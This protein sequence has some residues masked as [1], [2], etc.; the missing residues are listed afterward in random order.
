MNHIKSTTLSNC[1]KEPIHIPGAIQPFAYV[2]ILDSLFQVVAV[3]ENIGLLLNLK[4]EQCIGRNISEIPLLNSISG[5]EIQANNIITDVYFNNSSYT[6]HV[7]DLAPKN[8]YIFLEIESS[9]RNLEML[10]EQQIALQKLAADFTGK[11]ESQDFFDA[12]VENIRNYTG[13]DRCM[14]Y[15]FDKDWNG[16][17]IAESKEAKLEAFKG[18]HYPHTDIPTQARELYTKKLTRMIHDVNYSPV[19]LIQAS[20]DSS[21]IDLSKIDSRAIS[22]MHIQYLSNMGVKATLVLSLLVEGKLW[23]LIACHHYGSE[24]LLNYAER[25]ACGTF[26]LMV[27]L[28]VERMQRETLSQRQAGVLKKLS[29]MALMGILEKPF[30]GRE[31]ANTLLN[32]TQCDGIAFVEGKTIHT[33]KRVVSTEF[34]PELCKESDIK[35][36][37]PRCFSSLAWLDSDESK[38]AGCAGAIVLALPNANDNNCQRNYIVLFRKEITQ[39]VNWAGNPNEK[40]QQAVLNDVTMLSPRN[41]FALWQE[42]MSGSCRDWTEADLQIINSLHALLK[43]AYF[44][45]SQK[46]KNIEIQ[47]IA[48][49]SDIGLWVMDIQSGVLSWSDAMFDIYGI[50][51]SSFDNSYE[52]WL[53]SVVEEER[54]DIAATYERC[55]HEK[56]LFQSTFHIKNPKTGIRL[57][58]AH[59]KCVLS[60]AGDVTRIVGTNVDI[61][62]ELWKTDTNLTANL[63]TAEQSR[64]ISLGEMTAMVG[65]EINNPL[66]VILNS[67]ELQELEINKL[68][69]MNPHILSHNTRA[70]KASKRIEKIVSGLRSLTRRSYTDVQSSACKAYESVQEIVELMKELFGKKG[71]TFTQNLKDQDTWVMIENSL[72]QQILVNLINN[73]IYAL[74]DIKEKSIKIEGNRVDDAYVINVIDNG[75]G[76]PQDVIEKI[77]Q[78]F[79]TTKPS[80]KGTGLGLPISRQLLKQYNGDIKLESL[81]GQGTKVTITLKVT[82]SPCEKGIE[83]SVNHKEITVNKVL[84]VDD[85]EDLLDVLKLQVETLGLESTI[86][87]SPQEGLKKIK[88]EH[89]DIL[90]VDSQMPLMSGEE[91][92]SNLP[93]EH[94]IFVVL[95]TGDVTKTID[96]LSKLGIKVN[97]LLHKP[98]G[99]AELKNVLSEKEI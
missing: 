28:L 3:S 27:S 63:Q 34:Y 16:E 61:T 21:P 41:S 57:V 9:K 70:K 47:V 44:S 11:S 74:E 8:S 25:E 40:T 1:D 2:I 15:R 82:S 43:E 60:E 7:T 5:T 62:D 31:V 50:E 36:Q 89:F 37:K 52:S 83:D 65:H 93:Q 59:G 54:D 96:G 24:K 23:G 30:T 66:S 45:L 4:P 99:L 67:L 33:Y 46:R 29:P 69:I 32:L 71:I 48:E 86:A 64:L 91:M 39:V 68:P 51:Q 73:S 35:D 10:K 49:T 76:I 84:I 72:L 6:V 26:A 56:Q 19:P 20:N 38:L 87:S 12:I 90:L 95:M 98:F 85:E 94:Q 81:K 92:I 75:A 58:R 14:L 77:F 79:Y 55:V 88:E 17:V 80:G 42:T 22:P 78:A 18:L 97:Q 53:S 13:Y